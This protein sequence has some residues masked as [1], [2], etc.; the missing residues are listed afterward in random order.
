[1][2]DTITKSHLQL[3]F[4]L[5]IGFIHV[6]PIT[7]GQ[8]RIQICSLLSTYG[9]ASISSLV[10]ALPSDLTSI[11]GFITFENSTYHTLFLR[12]ILILSF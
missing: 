7:E 1:M 10:V 12:S 6:V 4:F 9:S 11:P 3:V 8:K 2:L 5:R